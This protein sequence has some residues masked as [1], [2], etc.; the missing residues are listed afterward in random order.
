MYVGTWL[1]L[2]L[3]LL[4][5]TM[6]RNRNA[7]AYHIVESLSLLTSCSGMSLVN[8][9]LITAAVICVQQRAVFA[10]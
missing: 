8:C 1:R 7:P 9:F 2:I 4:T 6:F 3:T 10:R 5:R